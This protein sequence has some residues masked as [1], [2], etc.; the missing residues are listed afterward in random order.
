M[1]KITTICAVITLLAIFTFVIAMP[2]PA[3]A[4]NEIVLKDGGNCKGT[5]DVRM[6]TK[7]SMPGGFPTWKNERTKQLSGPNPWLIQINQIQ[8][9]YAEIIY[10]QAFFDLIELTRGKDWYDKDGHLVINSSI[11]L[12]PGTIMQYLVIAS[13]GDYELAVDNPAVLQGIDEIY[14]FGCGCGF[15]QLHDGTWGMACRQKNF[16]ERAIDAAN[17]EKLQ[18]S[19]LE[20]GT[21][22]DVPSETTIDQIPVN[23]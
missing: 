7:F 23:N 22:T 20:E 13:F 6:K 4:G 12:P 15:K 17:A 11:C 18:M 19:V 16:V 5:N 2:T 14:G 10:E 21:D 8:K 1:K 9:I 3:T